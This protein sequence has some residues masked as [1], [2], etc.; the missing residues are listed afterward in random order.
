MQSTLLYFLRVQG[1]NQKDAVLLDFLRG[2]VV[3]LDPLE[4]GKPC[5]YRAYMEKN[6]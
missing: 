4:K 3:P 5:G 6:L 1:E 2:D